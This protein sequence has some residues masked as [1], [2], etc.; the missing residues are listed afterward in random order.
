MSLWRH[1]SRGLHVLTHR[2]AADQDI[3][4]EVQHFL[5]QMAPADR[6]AARATMARE[7]VRS[8]GWE[9]AIDQVLADTRYAARRLRAS[10]GFTRGTRA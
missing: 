1:V 9:N 4:D 8:Y 5:D 2:R 10:P 7:Q 3:A 6:S